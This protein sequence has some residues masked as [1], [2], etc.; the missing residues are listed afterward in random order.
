MV[1]ST[2]LNDVKMASSLQDLHCISG[3]IGV[4]LCNATFLST[5]ISHCYEKRI[6]IVIATKSTRKFQYL[7]SDPGG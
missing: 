3:I 4:K 6:V 1:E 2:H 5:E 7:A